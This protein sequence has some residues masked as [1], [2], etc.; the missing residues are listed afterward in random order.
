MSDPDTTYTVPPTNPWANAQSDTLR[1]PEPAAC[2]PFRFGF[3]A[4]TGDLW[5]GDVGEGT[6][7]EV[8]SLAGR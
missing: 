1:G 2:N 7:E 8:D 5:A 6:F 3:D 4:L